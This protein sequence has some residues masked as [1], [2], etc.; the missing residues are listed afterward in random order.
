MGLSSPPPPPVIRHPKDQGCP[1]ELPFPM[2]DPAA[3]ATMNAGRHSGAT[4]LDKPVQ[5]IRV[6]RQPRGGVDGADRD[7]PLTQLR[8][9][10]A[11]S[12]PLRG[13]RLPDSPD[14]HPG[15]ARRSASPRQTN[16][17]RDC[18]K[19]VQIRRVKNPSWAVDM[20]MGSPQH[21][22]GCRVGWATG[23]PTH[24]AS[25]SS[26][27]T[28]RGPEWAEQRGGHR[29]QGTIEDAINGASRMAQQRQRHFEAPSTGSTPW[30]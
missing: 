20:A 19:L 12:V 22:H 4:T 11:P 16:P 9:R 23:H 14:G 13:C 27:R 10:Q 2:R 25:L 17:R 15:E 29:I 1:F 26:R 3:A 8:S 6:C 7:V 28:P 5:P 21:P 30:P 18:C 24:S